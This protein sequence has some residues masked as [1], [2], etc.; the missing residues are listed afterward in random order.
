VAE[1]RERGRILKAS[2]AYS[3]RVTR[4]SKKEKLI[5]RLVESSRMVERK[6]FPPLDHAKWEIAAR[7]YVR[8]A[9]HFERKE[10]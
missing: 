8:R 2:E 6:R 3:W 7:A 1:S 9:I 5:A 10:S 4:R